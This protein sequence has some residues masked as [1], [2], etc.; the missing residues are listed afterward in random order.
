[1][2]KTFAEGPRTAEELPSSADQQSCPC[3]RREEVEDQVQV[4]VLVVDESIERVVWVC[5]AHELSQEQDDHHKE[6]Q[7]VCNVDEVH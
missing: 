2:T 6:S 4:L 1:M 3:F 7:T 5:V